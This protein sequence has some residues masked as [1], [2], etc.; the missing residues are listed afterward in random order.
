MQN[1]GTGRDRV[2][3]ATFLYISLVLFDRCM[4]TLA[5]KASYKNKMLLRTPQLLCLTSKCSIFLLPS[6]WNMKA[7]SWSLGQFRP[8]QRH[9]EYITIGAEADMSL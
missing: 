4:Y 1:W 9:E 3:A 5:E 8:V 6:Q 7:G 2:E